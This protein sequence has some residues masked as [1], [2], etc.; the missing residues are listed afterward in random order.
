MLARRSTRALS[1]ARSISQ[2]PPAVTPH[3]RT[4]S[5]VVRISLRSYAT[6]G[7]NNSPRN[8]SFNLGGQEPQPGEAL[9]KYS[10]DLTELAKTGKLDPVIGRDEEIRRTIQILSRR[11]KNN[12]ALVG[13]AGVGK[14]AIM[15]GLAQR[16]I[17]GEVPASLQKKKVVSLDLSALIS[18][19]K[20]RG[21]F[22]ERLQAVLKD[23]K[24]AQGEIIT[25]IDEL[26]I[27]LG[28]GKAEGSV[29]AGNMLKPSLARGELQCCGAT[30]LN[31]YRQYIEKDAALARRFQPVMINEPTVEDTISI[32][33][34]LKERYE[35]NENRCCD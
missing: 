11:T 12:A 19:A 18:G 17:R 26:H 23:I 14:T 5:P 2:I 21:E 8:F 15:E 22:E 29:D 16:I 7:N 33:R 13:A 27:L 9:K 3:L 24:A 4:L 34:G 6:P 28:L 31:E 32:L 30:T 35:G 20:Y 1:L 10:I 25:F